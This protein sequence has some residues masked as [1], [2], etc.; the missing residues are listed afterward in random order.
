MESYVRKVYVSGGKSA[1]RSLSDR[2]QIIYTDNLNDADYVIILR[3]ENEA[4][5]KEQLRDFVLAKEAGKRIKV[6][7]KK[8]RELMRQTRRNL[9]M[10]IE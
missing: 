3:G 10:E 2:T 9:D 4:L 6:E 8:N 1:K 5:Q 7:E